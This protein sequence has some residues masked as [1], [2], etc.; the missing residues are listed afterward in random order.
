MNLS[1]SASGS[2]EGELVVDVHRLASRALRSAVGSQTSQA[3]GARFGRSAQMSTVVIQR[4]KLAFQRECGR[5]V[6]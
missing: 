1:G 3:R 4:A 6:E 5:I 2:I